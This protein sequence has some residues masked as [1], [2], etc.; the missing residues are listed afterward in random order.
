MIKANTV[1]ILGA[2]AS[3]PY[4][5]PLGNGLTWKIV[6]DIIARRGSI[7]PALEALGFTWNKQLKFAQELH[8]AN[9]PSIDA[10][11]QDRKDEFGDIGKA[12]IAATLIPYEDS[13]NLMLME[14]EIEFEEH[15]NKRWYGYLLNLMGN[16]ESF[17]Q[18]NL[19]IVTFNYDRSLE[20]FLFQTIGAR[21]GS[22]E[23]AIKLVRSLPIIHVYGQLGKPQFLDSRGRDYRPVVDRETVMKSVEEIHLMYE[24]QTSPE[25]EEMIQLIRPAKLLVFIG[26]GYHEKNLAQVALKDNCSNGARIVST[27]FKLAHGEKERALGRLKYYA[28]AKNHDVEIIQELETD[29]LGFLRDYNLLQ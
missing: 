21:C 12:A 9:P 13:K 5:F 19:S 4:G 18:N 8:H 6:D 16:L 29:A 20:Y 22:T 27:F 7:A 1:L 15:K 26:F 3:A 28:E 24:E 14:Q 2:G 17:E 11:L 25:A 10:F 23:E